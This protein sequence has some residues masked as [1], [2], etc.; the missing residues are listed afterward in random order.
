M[1]FSTKTQDDYSYYII[2]K[3]TLLYRGDTPA[4]IYEYSKNNTITFMN[5]PYFFGTSEKDVSSYGIIFEFETTREYNLLALD[6]K[7]NRTKLYKESNEKIRKILEQNYGYKNGIRYSVATAD[8]ELTDYLCNVLHMDGYA[9][10]EME[11]DTGY[12]HPELMICDTTHIKFNKIITDEKEIDSLIGEYTVRKLA[13]ER[14]TKKR[15]SPSPNRHQELFII[16]NNNDEYNKTPIKITPIKKSLFSDDDENN[17]KTPSPISKRL[18]NGGKRKTVHRKTKK[19][20][21]H[22]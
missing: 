15:R 9:N 10:S 20:K 13:P 17:N 8:K 5:T 16:N 12:F 4:Y 18:F 6:D 1:N 7:Q 21:K 22:H 2:P 11:T 14:K 3:G 19:S